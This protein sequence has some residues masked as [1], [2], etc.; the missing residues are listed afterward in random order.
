[1]TRLTGCAGFYAGWRG[2]MLRLFCVAPVFAVD[3]ACMCVCVLVTGDKTGCV[4]T[5]SGFQF[6]LFS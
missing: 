3:A 5:G 1:M 4:N 2:E 6:L